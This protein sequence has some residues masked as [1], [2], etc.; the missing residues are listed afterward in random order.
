[1]VL[2]SVLKLV[3]IRPIGPGLSHLSGSSLTSDR[4]CKRLGKNQSDS[5]GTMIKPV[6]RLVFGLTGE[7]PISFFIFFSVAMGQSN[8]HTLI[9]WACFFLIYFIGPTFETIQPKYV[10]IFKKLVLVGLE[11]GT[12]WKLTVN[13]TTEPLVGLVI[14][15]VFNSFILTAYCI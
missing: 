8:S 5:A 10:I 6:I 2:I 7:S 1:M 14:S 11:H 15:T 4:T 12:S 9:Y 13:L 3:Q